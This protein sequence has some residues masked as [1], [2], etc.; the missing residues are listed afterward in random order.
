M[1]KEDIERI[2]AQSKKNLM[3]IREEERKACIERLKE[4]KQ[5]IKDNFTVEVEKPISLGGQHCGIPINAI[6][7]KSE[8]LQIEIKVKQFRSNYQNRD[9]ALLLMELAMDEIIK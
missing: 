5:A 7:V 4:V 9:L 2:K 8:E 3:K 6:V 1:K